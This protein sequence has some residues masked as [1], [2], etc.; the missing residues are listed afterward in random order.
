MVIFIKR[1]I[2]WHTIIMLEHQ[3]F[4]RETNNGWSLWRKIRNQ[5]RHWVYFSIHDTTSKLFL[6]RSMAFLVH[7]VT[8]TLLSFISLLDQTTVSLHYIE[9]VDHMLITQ[10]IILLTP[11]VLWPHLNK[12]FLFQSCKINSGSVSIKRIKTHWKSFHVLKAYIF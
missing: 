12:L 10:N 3:P 2:S 7:E 4:I 8:V 9:Q 1:Y 11:I 5:G 6:A